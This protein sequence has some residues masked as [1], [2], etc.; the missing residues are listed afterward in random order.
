MFGTGNRV[1]KFGLLI[2]NAGW[3]VFAA[4][5]FDIIYFIKFNKNNLPI[6][7]CMFKKCIISLLVL[8]ESFTIF[9]AKFIL[10]N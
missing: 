6:T 9:N 4:P 3:F 10:R 2:D 1:T 7:K 5:L 8:E